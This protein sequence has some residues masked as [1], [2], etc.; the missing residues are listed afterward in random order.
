MKFLITA[1]P[2]REYIDPVRFISNAS[3]GKMGYS[4]AKAAK[5]RGH[6]VTLISTV[7]LQPPVGVDFIGVDSADEMFG[8][9]K[10]VFGESECLIMAA[11]VADYTPVNRSQTKLKKSEK[12]LSI[13]LKATTDILKWAGENKVEGQLV[14]G[15]ALEDRNMRENAAAK[16]EDK[17][18]DVII[19]NR[20][21]AIG[22]E[23]A[24]F[25][26]MVKGLEW[27]VM[28]DVSKVDLSKRIIEVAE[29]M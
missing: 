8:A 20:P 12:N 13:E 29:D 4:L 16:M 2:T 26:M 5:D 11:A 28:E 23:K 17:N 15:F 1:G 27:S 22:A 25:H 6:E 24:T 7:E 9:V 10:R 3:S 14:V 21:S 18:L 19:A